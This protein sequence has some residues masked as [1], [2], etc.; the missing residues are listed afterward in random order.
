MSICNNIKHLKASLPEGVTLVAVSKYHPKEAILEAYNA[1][2]RIFGESRA[3]ELVAKEKS[4]PADIEWHFIGQLQTNKVKEI[5]SFIHTIHSIDSL[6]LINETEKQAAKQNRIIRI[7]LEIHLAQE[8]T[9]SGFTP[10][11]CKN[12]LSTLSLK[13]YPHLQIDGLMTMATN[14]E[15]TEQIHQEFR[16]LRILFEELK[17]S[18]F[19]NSANFTVLSMGMSADYP[20]AISEGSNMIRIGSK[21]FEV[22]E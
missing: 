21:I 6:K 8:A 10:E 14:T 20:I 18:Y 3:Q 5:A 15:N 19:Q 22:R 12:L 9:K 16:R 11:E 4:L 2:Q 7:L 17:N 13:D 1:G